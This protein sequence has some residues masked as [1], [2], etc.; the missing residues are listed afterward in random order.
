ML[1]W[2]LYVVDRDYEKKIDVLRGMYCVSSMFMPYT[3][4]FQMRRFR[5]CNI[6]NTET[7]FDILT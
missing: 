3:A 1:R 2:G 5:T 7:N 4:S 6:L